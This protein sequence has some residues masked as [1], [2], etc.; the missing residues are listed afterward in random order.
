VTLRPAQGPVR[1][2]QGPAYTVAARCSNPNCT[3]WSDDPHHIWSRKHLGGPFDWVAVMTTAGEYVC[4]NKTGVCRPCHDDLTGRG[5]GHK[6]RI[7][8]DLK[9]RTFA[10]ALGATGPTTG[11]LDP[12]PPTPDSLTHV[13]GQRSESE[14]PCPFCGQA[15]RR[16]PAASRAPGRRRKT[17]RVLVPADAEDGADILDALVEDVGLTLGIDPAVSGRYYILLPVLYHACQSKAA[18]VESLQGVGG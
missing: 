13:L 5:G 2:V 1:G 3:S 10:W 6:A 4:A 8:F 15:K 12:Q 18:L 7:I 16:R 11:F 9:S 17:W 14:E